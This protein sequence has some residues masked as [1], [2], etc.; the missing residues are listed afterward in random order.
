MPVFFTFFSSSVC[1]DAGGF[2]V[3]SLAAVFHNSPPI[4][5]ICFPLHP[6]VLQGGKL[7][8]TIKGRSW[9]TTVISFSKFSPLLCIIT[10]KARL[11][12][13]KE[14]LSKQKKSFTP[15]NFKPQVRNSAW[16][17]RKEEGR[18]PETLRL[19]VELNEFPLGTNRLLFNRLNPLC[20]ITDIN[21]KTNSVIKIK[22]WSSI[23]FLFL[24]FLRELS[25]PLSGQA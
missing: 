12:F 15:H 25:P 20:F 7:T 3:F 19:E 14:H 5:P 23:L 8:Q 17:I 6:K 4:S 2:W 16:W 1:Q 13:S 11:M 10:I 18:K 24:L 9:A 21:A 22:A